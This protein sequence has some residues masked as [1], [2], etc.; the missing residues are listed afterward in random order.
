MEELFESFKLLLGYLTPLLV[1]ILG[2]FFKWIFKYFASYNLWNRLKPILVILAGIIATAIAK[3]W[4]GEELNSATEELKKLLGNT[5][6][7]TLLALTLYRLW[8]VIIKNK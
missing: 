4:Y 8:K 7:I 3:A 5:G 6:F 2:G 1:I